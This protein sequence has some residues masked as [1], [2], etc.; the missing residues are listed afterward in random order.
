MIKLKSNFDYATGT[1]SD[2]TENPHKYQFKQIDD[3]T[4]PRIHEFS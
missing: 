3:T 1:V 4:G 2:I